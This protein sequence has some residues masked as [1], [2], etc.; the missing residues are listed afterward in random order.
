M[1]LL[2]AGGGTGGHLFPGVAIAQEFL[3]RGHHII[4]F[5]LFLYRGIRISLKAP[6]LFGTYLAL[7]ITSLISFQAI[8][9]IAVV[10]GLLPTKG[11]AL[12]FLSYGGTSVICNLAGVGILLNISAQQQDVSTS[13]YR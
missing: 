12:P 6:D 9:N 1:K 13:T 11:L 2:I 7:G 8:T 3:S 10:M 4:L 5:V